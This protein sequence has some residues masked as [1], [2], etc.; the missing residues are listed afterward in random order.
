MSGASS[1]SRWSDRFSAMSFSSLA[2]FS[3]SW[4][5]SPITSSLISCDLL[6][7][8]GCLLLLQFLGLA[9]VALAHGLGDPLHLESDPLVILVHRGL[10]L[11]EDAGG[12]LGGEVV[13]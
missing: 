10:K 6:I 11:V 4:S 9:A 1:A 2:F 3:G 7:G 12:R 8:I 13:A 5:L